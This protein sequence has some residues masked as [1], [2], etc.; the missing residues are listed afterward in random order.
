V[1]LLLEAGANVNHFNEL[2]ITPLH[3]S[4]YREHAHVVATLIEY[5][6]NPSVVDCF[7]RNS[8]DW[9]EHLSIFKMIGQSRHDFRTTPI[10][11]QLQVL[12][13]STRF[14]IE[15]AMQS[16]SDTF[17]GELGHCLIYLHDLKEAKQA[18]RQA[19]HSV[20]TTEIIVHQASCN[21]FP[22]PN[23]IQGERYACQ[24][25]PDMDLCSSCLKKYG[26]I[27]SDA[28]CRKHQFLQVL[29]G[30]SENTQMTE[31]QRWQ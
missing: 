9:A 12:R 17:M 29:G 23:D 26:T 25:C 31:I 11:E 13:K 5:G 16:I 21:F 3:L 7:R 10:S 8:L 2:G 30:N 1:K 14:L 15:K 27:R 19:I 24:T 6:A 28:W 20:R 22:Q 4:M 18:F